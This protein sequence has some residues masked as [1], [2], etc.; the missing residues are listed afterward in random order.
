MRD[1]ER[2]G[3]RAARLE[4]RLDCVPVDRVFYRPDRLVA[5]PAERHE[6]L[7]LELLDSHDFLAGAHHEYTSDGGYHLAVRRPHRM[8]TSGSRRAAAEPGSGRA[9]RTA[10]TIPEEA[11]TA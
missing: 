6:P 7:D 10:P 8:R 2:G 1:L 11:Q 3:Q 9:S 5:P 4:K